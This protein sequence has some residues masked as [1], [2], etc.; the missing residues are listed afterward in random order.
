[1]PATAPPMD[2]QVSRRAGSPRATRSWVG[3]DAAYV[4]PGR[5]TPVCGM[6]LPQ[7]TG[8]HQVGAMPT[9]QSGILPV[10]MSLNMT[11]SPAKE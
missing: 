9:G 10:S 3:Q 8:V 6:A 11:Q 7:G 2:G 4:R 5:H 1:M